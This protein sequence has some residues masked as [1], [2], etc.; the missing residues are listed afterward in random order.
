MYYTFHESTV[1]NTDGML[2]NGF[3]VVVFKCEAT[4]SDKSK[5]KNIYLS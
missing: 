3:A 5:S 2:A 4:Q 1:I